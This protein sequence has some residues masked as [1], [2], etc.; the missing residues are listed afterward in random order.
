LIRL[1]RQKSSHT[2]LSAS[3]CLQLQTSSHAASKAHILHRPDGTAEAVP[4]PDL[5]SPGDCGA[6]PLLEFRKLSS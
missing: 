3:S 4:L 5:L 1:V 6:T 2:S